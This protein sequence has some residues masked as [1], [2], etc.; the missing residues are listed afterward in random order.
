MIG[1]SSAENPGS[2]RHGAVRPSP[3]RVTGRQIVVLA[4]TGDD[5]RVDWE[6]MGVHR[7]ADS[8]DFADGDVSPTALS[9]AEATVFSALGIAVVSAEPEQVGM[10]QSAGVAGRPVLSVSPELVHHVLADGSAGPYTAGYRDGVADLA[11]RLLAPGGRAG[12]SGGPAQARFEDTAQATWGIQAVRADSSARS[13]RGIRVAVLDTG[14]D[15]A[16]P[17]FAGRAVTTR[18]FVVGEDASD[19]HGHGTHCIGT[20]C[21]PRSPS[22]G[23]RYGVAYEAE[24]YAGKVLGTDGSG[25][26][27]GILAGINWAVTSGCPVISMSLGA[28]V[29]QAHPPYSAAGRRAL[30]Q[31]SLIIAAAGNNA[32]RRSGNSGFVGVPANSV[33]IMAVGAL[34][35]AMAMA[36][37]S[38]QSLPARGGQVDIAAPGWQVYSAWPM[39]TRYHTI[40]GTSMATPHVAGLAALWAEATGRRG[41]ELWATLLQESERLA[42]SSLDAGSGLAVAPE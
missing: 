22:T 26:D 8:R 2:V 40:S 19:G 36:D 34:D 37:F 42:Q 1:P 13:G 18:S 23:P 16:H 32:D 29:M 5:A 39:P 15:A 25:T 27:A 6:R 14:F 30:Q 12:E 35:E 38:A 7:V 41:L 31:G 9:E 20:A 17:D 28:D 4:G 33:E 21:G 3:P 11:G 10:L 24:I